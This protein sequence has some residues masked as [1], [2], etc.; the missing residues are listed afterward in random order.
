[1]APP[2]RLRLPTAPAR[3]DCSAPA[4]AVQE[5]GAPVRR[6]AQLLCQTHCERYAPEASLRVR[7]RWS[8]P[9]GTGKCM[10]RDGGDHDEDLRLVS[11]TLSGDKA[12]R[13]ELLR[14]LACVPLILRVRNQRLGRPLDADMLQDV[15]QDT[16]I[17]VWTRLSTFGGAS[18]LEAWVYRFCVHKHL[19]RIRDHG[20]RVRIEAVESPLLDSAAARA[21]EPTADEELV[22]RSLDDLDA[23]RAR[24]V[25]L[26]HFE[27]LTFEQIAERL[28]IS[29]N[30]AKTHYYRALRVLRDFFSRRGNKELS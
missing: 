1:M 7:Q 8:R 19:T 14:R 13:E 22:H 15:V 20:R 27:D 18:S 5:A 11:A 24:I 3:L 30:T 10:L 26:K 29:P 16:L 2:P 17:A 12:A 4:I 23:D 25:R 21:V 9:A 6:G 28:D